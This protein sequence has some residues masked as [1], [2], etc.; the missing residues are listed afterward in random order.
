[1]LYSQLRRLDLLEGELLLRNVTFSGY[2]AFD[3]AISVD[4]GA[5]L[6][7]KDIQFNTT[8]PGFPKI[9]VD[10]ISQV[11]FSFAQLSLA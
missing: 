7:V 9:V 6:I 5:K 11:M 1:M 10:H 3:E 4:P 8:K 2:N